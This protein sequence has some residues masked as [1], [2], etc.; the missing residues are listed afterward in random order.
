M[1][2]STWLAATRT[3]AFAQCEFP[4]GAA[5]PHLV[6]RPKKRVGAARNSVDNFGRCEIVLF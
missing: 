5:R 6:S 1:L 4:G 2:K 3:L